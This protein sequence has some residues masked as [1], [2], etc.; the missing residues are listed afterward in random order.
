MMLGRC[1]TRRGLECHGQS[2]WI[3]GFRKLPSVPEAGNG[4]GCATNIPPGRRSPGYIYIAIYIY[5]VQLSA[6]KRQRWVSAAPPEPRFRQ[7]I[8]PL[9]YSATVLCACAGTGPD[10]GRLLGLTTGFVLPL[11]GLMHCG[12]MEVFAANE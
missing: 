8:P 9:T 11:V 10:R 6:V 4:R 3:K 5:G 12:S 7:H 1:R 2:G